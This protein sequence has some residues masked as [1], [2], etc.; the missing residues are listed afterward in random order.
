MAGLARQH[1][2]SPQQYAVR[3]SCEAVGEWETKTEL[4]P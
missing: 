3:I 2:S 1:A 4:G